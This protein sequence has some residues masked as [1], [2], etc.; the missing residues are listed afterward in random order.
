M[1]LDRKTGLS[2]WTGSAGVYYQ[3]SRPSVPFP[4]SKSWD[5][6]LRLQSMLNNDAQVT[7]YSTTKPTSDHDSA[8]TAGL[9]RPFRVG[10]LWYNNTDNGLYICSD[11]TAGA[12]VWKDIGGITANNSSS[13]SSSNSSSSS[14][15]SSSSSKSSSSDS[16][17]S[18]SSQSSSSDS[19]MS[20]SSQSSSSS[21]LGNSS[22]SSTVAG[23]TSSSSSS[24]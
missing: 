3:A 8:D 2:G 5:D 6:Y 12:A 18:S 11:H 9:G 10:A 4:S 7:H 14:S 16:T 23:N 19:T 21:S 17:L 15:D 22:S 1:G 24:P 13:S 20:S